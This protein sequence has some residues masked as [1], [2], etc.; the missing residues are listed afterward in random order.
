MT[1]LIVV[2]GTI[3]WHTDLRRDPP[4]YF[5]GI[6]QSLST[7]PAQYT[8]HARNEVLFGQWDPFDY[9]RWTV[10][11]HS[12]TSLVAYAWFALTDISLES[13]GSVGLTLSV[14]GL[15]FLLIGVARHHRPWVLAAIA[16]A[17]MLNITLLT[18]G[19]LSYL[20]DGLIL[21]AAMTFCCYSWFG[22]RLWGVI[23]CGALAAAAMLMGK[24]FGGLLLPALILTVVFSPREHR[25]RDALV[26]V[27]AFVTAA[28][29]LALVLYGREIA[30]AFTYTGEQAYELRGFPAGLKSPWAFIEHLVSFGFS[31]RLFYL[32]PDLLVFTVI[33]S[34]LAVQFRLD[35]KHLSPAARFAMFWGLCAFVGLMP[36]NYSP[37]RYTLLLIPAIIVFCFTMFDSTSR[38][39]MRQP[40]EYNRWTMVGLTAALWVALF[41]VAGNV[42]FFN[43]FPRPIRA[44]VWLTLP[45]AIGLAYLLYRILKRQRSRIY[46][47]AWWS[48]LAVVVLV[49]VA[50]NVTRISRFYFDERNYTIAEANIDMAAIL[51]PGAV[52][53][54]PYGPALTLATDLKSFIH[55]FQVAEVKPDLFDSN[56]I[57]HVAMDVSNYNE[58]I[59][60]YPQLQGLLPVAHYWIRDVEV[61]LYRVSDRFGNA[62]ANAYEP[63]DFERAA[64]FLA[65]SEIDSAS[66]LAASAYARH[67]GSKSA[68]LLLAETYLRL[69][70]Y[71]RVY[72]LLMDLT[73]RFRTDFWVQLQ[74]GRFLQLLALQR[75]DSQLANM[76]QRYYQ[77]AVS[78]DHYRADYAMRLWQK[79]A[80]QSG[81]ASSSPSPAPKKNRPGE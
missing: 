15:L 55:L 29:V 49:T 39:L 77:R 23:L 5:A 32:N 22:H 2:A 11:Q 7:D 52:V 65:A 54:G 73:D 76:A 27:S 26:A 17:Y 75:Q 47:R 71:D 12:L 19:R 57:T 50:G 56:P 79:T 6:G 21:L 30:A 60:D 43:T 20:E 66:V 74:C 3:A 10:Y 72:G 42:F 38:G 37:I 51:G 25:V 9:P 16:L 33:G 28:L 1:A 24:M 64:A 80:R 8:Y 31:N 44:T 62:V 35:Q 34:M 59:Q 69:G 45:V 70:Q 36:L 78:A 68:G 41:E 4:M 48:A 67:P 61:G 13:A 40:G 81:S 46:R 53:S 63:S 14:L 18:H 58:A